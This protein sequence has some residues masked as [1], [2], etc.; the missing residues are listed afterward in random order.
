MKKHLLY[1]LFLI[2]GNQLFCQQTVF[3][4]FTFTP[5]AGWIK[6]ESTGSV[7]YSITDPTS[8]NWCQLIL[9]KKLYGQH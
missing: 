7:T 5:P 2:P 9:C 8:K 4:L 1:L 6:T 3:D